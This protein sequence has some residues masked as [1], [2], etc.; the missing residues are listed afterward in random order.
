MH[1]VLGASGHVGSV[2]VDEL[3]RRGEPVTVVTRAPHR[4]E[5]FVARGAKVAVVDLDDTDALANLFRR[6]R[7]AFVLLPPADP[8]TDTVAIERRRVSS[9]VRALRGSTVERAVVQSTYG[10]QAGEGIGDLGVL[11][12][13]E[14]GVLALGIRAS[15]VRGAY[16]MSNWDM[17][18][19]SAREAGEVPSFLPEDFALPMVAAADL[20]RVGAR[21][22]T[23]DAG[24][25]GR[26]YVEGPRVYSPADVARAFSV[27]LA[28]EVRVV[29]IP[30][31]E[32][33]ATFR[34]LGFSAA[35]AA[36]Y[37]RM[38]EIT[39]DSGAERP[40]SPERGRVTLADYIA[41]LVEGAKEINQR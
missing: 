30:R 24:Q 37:A 7:S 38:T 4:A 36:S 3:L 2:V 8:T 31:A 6:A 33:E 20:G 29:E 22:L 25:T 17:A 21:L 15:I 32:W 14:Q 39:V 11:H 35:A 9:I 19:T 34:T 13:L 27:A 5:R 12:E 26:H 23:D 18:L 10:A 1:V 16:Y 40:A 28:R 41:A